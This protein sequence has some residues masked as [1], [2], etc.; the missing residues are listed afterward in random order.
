T[1]G[2]AVGLAWIPFAGSSLALAVALGLVVGGQGVA[3]P[4]LS[5]LISKTSAASVHGTAL[6]VG[7]SLSAAARVI[8]PAGGGL[9]LHHL[10]WETPYVAAAVC[11]VGAFGIVVPGLREEGRPTEPVAFRSS[12]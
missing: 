7:Q 10:G 2:L 8:G 6:G 11:A 12:G 9:L 5:S 3:S 1:L 4:S